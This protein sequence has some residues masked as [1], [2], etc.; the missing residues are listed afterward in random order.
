[1]FRFAFVILAGIGLGAIL[2]GGA[3]SA[4]TGSTLL[5]RAAGS[6]RVTEVHEAGRVPELKFD[7]DGERPV[8]LLDGEELA[9]AKQNRVLN[10]TI[11]APPKRSIVIPVSCVEAGRWEGAASQALFRSSPQLM[12]HSARRAKTLSV[13]R[14]MA[15]AGSPFSR[16]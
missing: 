6:A 8:L 16:A 14:A 7:N 4:A 10:L 9:G 13:S 11:L 3:P 5:A 15:T 1:M 2:F 12:F